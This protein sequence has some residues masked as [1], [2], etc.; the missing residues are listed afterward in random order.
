MS[1]KNQSGLSL[2]G[3][4]LVGGVLAAVIL[5][6]L[7]LIPVVSE[8][9]GIKR[10]INAVVSSAD[11]QVATVPQ[12]RMAFTKRAMVDDI[13]SISA[14]DLD[15]TKENGQIVISADYSRKV[16]LFSNV[17]LMIDFSVSTSQGGR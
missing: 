2:V 3:V 10:A 12:L 16:P 6:G 8:Y 14:S 17:N 9:F 13:S 5:L 15:I 4:L 11:P 7:K 1:K